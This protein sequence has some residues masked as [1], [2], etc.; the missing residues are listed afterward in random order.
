MPEYITSYQ[1]QVADLDFS[2]INIERNQNHRDTVYQV[3]YFSDFWSKVTV[4][5]LTFFFLISDLQEFMQYG[6]I[7]MQSSHTKQNY[8]AYL[9][10]NFPMVIIYILSN[11]LIKFLKCLGFS[12]QDM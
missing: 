7:P 2:Y 10:N 8:A 3:K 4:A 9:S 11:C 1:V 5:H 6:S 12:S